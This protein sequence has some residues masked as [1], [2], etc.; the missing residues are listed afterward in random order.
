ML[1]QIHLIFEHEDIHEC[2]LSAL[3]VPWV[4]RSYVFALHFWVAGIALRLRKLQVVV[5]GCFE[6]GPNQVRESEGS[7]RRADVGKAR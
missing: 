5:V 6:R 7:T 1:W 3:G 4:W 2:I